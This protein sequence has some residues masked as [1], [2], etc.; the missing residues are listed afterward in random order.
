[1]IFTFKLK[2]I[3][4]YSDGNTIHTNE[5]KNKIKNHNIYDR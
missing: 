3:T 4:N 2:V 1:M 5:Q